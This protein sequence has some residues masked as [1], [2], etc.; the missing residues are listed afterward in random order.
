MKYIARILGA[1]VLWPFLVVY[2]LF[3]WL[4]VNTLSILWNFNFNHLWIL[5]KEDFYFYIQRNGSEIS[6]I[7]I[8]NGVCN[9]ESYNRYYATPLDMIRGKITKKII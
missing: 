3:G 2:M 7:D 4:V 5:E 1:T 6:D 8:K 9:W